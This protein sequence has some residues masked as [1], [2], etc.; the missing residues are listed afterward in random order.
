MKTLRARFKKTEVSLRPPRCPVSPSPR[1]LS[2]WAWL[3]ICWALGRCHLSIRFFW[4]LPRDQGLPWFV[5][6]HRFKFIL[7]ASSGH[8]SVL[9][10]LLPPAATM[11]PPL[12]VQAFGPPS[13]SPGS[14]LHPECPLSVLLLVT[15]SPLLPVW[16]SHTSSGPRT[17]RSRL[18]NSP[19]Q[20]KVA[21]ETRNPACAHLQSP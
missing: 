21:A 19:S 9:S 12:L 20:S 18:V 14:R 8:L 3:R 7:L 11:S 16:L 1:F 5:S 2:P 6:A 15:P 13:R 17:P 10:S 4:K